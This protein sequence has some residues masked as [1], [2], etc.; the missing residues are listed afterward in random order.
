MCAVAVADWCDSAV[1]RAVCEQPCVPTAVGVGCGGC[2]GMGWIWVQRICGVQD[3]RVY[4]DRVWMGCGREQYCDGRV[5]GVLGRMAAIEGCC[6]M[7]T[8][9]VMKC[10]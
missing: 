3:G 10:D 2:V 7:Q 5:L 8:I 4:A 1:G 6:R 9:I